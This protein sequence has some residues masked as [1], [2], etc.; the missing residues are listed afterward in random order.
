MKKLV[1]A[2]PLKN[3]R[4]KAIRISI[5]NLPGRIIKRS[6]ELIVRLAHNHPSSDLLI[7]MRGKI[8]NLS[9]VILTG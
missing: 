5:I 8:L 1:F 3:K 4:M 7:K 9:P 6:Q 2:E